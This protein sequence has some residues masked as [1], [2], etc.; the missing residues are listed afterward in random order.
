MTYRA[1][2]EDILFTLRHVAGLDRLI[3]DGLA[4]DLEGDLA[5]AVLEEAGRFATDKVAPLNRVGDKVGSV[6]R[7]GKVTTPPGWKE[8]YAEWAAAGWNGLAAPVEHGGQGLPNLVQSACIDMWTAAS[9]A[10]ALGPAADG[11]RHRGARQPRFG[12]AEARLPAQARQRRVDGHDE[13]HRAAGGVRPQRPALARGTGG[14]GSYRIF[15]QKIYITYGDHDL[16][17]NIVHLVLARLPDAPPGTRGIS[18]FIVP[19]FLVNADGTLGAQNDVRCSGLEH[20][21]GIHASPTC[22]MVYGDE[23]GAVGWLV[24]EENRG[25][26]CMFTMMNNARLGIGLQ[27]VGVAERAYQQALAFAQ[28]RRQGRAPGASGDGMSPIVDHPDVK[29]MLLTMRAQTRAARAICYLT[30]EA[31]DRADRETTPEARKAAAE[32]AALLTPVAKAYS[33][34]DRHRGRLAGR[35]GPWRHGLR[36]GNRRG[37]A[38]ARRPD[39]G[40][41]RGHERHPG[42]RPRHA[43]T[44]AFGRRDGEGGH[45]PHARDRGQ[46]HP[47]ERARIRPFRGPA[48]RWPS[49]AWSAPP[50]GCW[51]PW[52]N[53]RA[54]RLLAR[55]PI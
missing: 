29:R 43:Q 37:A 12:R 36:R 11:R 55:R 16:T 8:T 40:D 25:L 1:P 27:G 14:D 35:A 39:R 13:P 34:R 30:A 26:A 15:G 5:D 28:E 19:K 49:T 4:P 3:A 7:D 18:L 33:T 31:L 54:R 6:L 47:P 23:G 48:E 42:H 50:S 52:L 17:D 20:K 45:R 41:L 21:L 9:S 46:A 2:V 51:P 10:F 44:A 53:A 22:T 38:H 32:R 24:G